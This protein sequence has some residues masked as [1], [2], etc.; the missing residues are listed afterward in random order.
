MS[1]LE[2]SHLRDMLVSLIFVDRSVHCLK[3][4]TK[5][6]VDPGV[7]QSS[8]ASVVV[9][10]VVDC[11]HANGVDAELLEVHDITR[12]S[13]L[14][15]KRVD[16]VG[17][18]SRLVINT[19]DIEAIASGK[20]RVALDCD[21]GKTSRRRAGS[22][23]LNLDGVGRSCSNRGGHGNRACNDRALHDGE[24]LTLK[25]MREFQLLKDQKKK[26]FKRQMQ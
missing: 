26:R 8:H 4:P 1:S 6:N 14:I 16:E 15:S 21:G 11:V 5:S 23:S 13:C 10:C 18:T 2:Y 20:E 17:R 9:G 22:T 19:T 3:T 7:G 25:E 12:A 24:I